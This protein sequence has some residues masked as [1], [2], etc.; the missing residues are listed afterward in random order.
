M[1]TS[2]THTHTRS[3]YCTRTCTHMDRV[4]T[5]TGINGVHLLA[6]KFMDC[7][8]ISKDE[9]FFA[10]ERFWQIGALQLTHVDSDTLLQLVDILVLCLHQLVH[11]VA[12]TLEGEGESA[13]IRFLC[14]DL[15]ILYYCTQKIKARKPAD[16]EAEV[17]YSV[18]TLYMFTHRIFS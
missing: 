17:C 10:F 3:T 6:M 18:V 9:L 15:L 5:Q 12:V 8:N 13:V 7:L 2:S 11:D 1:H 4:Y 14:Q 16:Q